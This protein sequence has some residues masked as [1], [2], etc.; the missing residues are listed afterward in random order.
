LVA[1]DSLTSIRLSGFER[2]NRWADVITELDEIKPIGSP[3]FY[4]LKGENAVLTKAKD[5]F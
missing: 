5:G 4:Y 1:G 3:E 2:T